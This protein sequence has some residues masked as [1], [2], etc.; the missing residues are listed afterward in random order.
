MAIID[1]HDKR[2]FRHY[3]K[4]GFD[5]TLLAFIEVAD[6][7]PAPPDDGAVHVDIT[8]LH[9]YEFPPGHKLKKSEISDNASIVAALA[10]ANRG[11]GRGR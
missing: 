4:I 5:G 6:T 7:A 11:R 8:L 9:P 2:P 10:V 3:A 1:P